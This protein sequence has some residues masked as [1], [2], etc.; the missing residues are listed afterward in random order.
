MHQPF[1][2]GHIDEAKQAATRQR[3]IGET[4]VDR[5]AAGLFRR[6]TI[7]VDAGQCP[8]KAGLAMVDMTG[9]ADDHAVSKASGLARPLSL[10]KAVSNKG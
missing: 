9:R 7:G 2:A 10:R 1:V 5:D 8:H 3:H 4:E 6:E